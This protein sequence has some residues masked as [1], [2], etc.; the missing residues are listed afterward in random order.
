MI[1]RILLLVTSGILI[2]NCSMNNHSEIK[3][4]K[5]LVEYAENP[6]NIDEGHPRF[7]WIISIDE[8]NQIQSAYRILVASSTLKLAENSGD[9]WN[10]GKVISSVTIQHEPEGISL[11]SNQKYFWKVMV[12]DGAGKEFESPVS[13]F[14]T[15]ILNAG[16]WQ[17]SWIGEGTEPEVLPEKGFI[18]SRKD[19]TLMKD[20]I[21]HHGNSILLRNEIDLP[22]KIKSAKTPYHKYVLYDSYDIAQLLK[23]GKNTLG[24]HLGNGWYNPYK[25][26]WNQYRMQWFGFKKAI[27]QIEITNEDGSSQI[28]KTD[29]NWKWADGPEISNCVYDGEIYDA[30]LDQQGWNTIDFDGS[31]WKAV[32]LY[33]TEKVRLVSQ[34]MP[35][36]KVN[37]TVKPRE[38]KVSVV[39]TNQIINTLC[40]NL[41]EGLCGNEDCGQ[42]SA[43]YVKMVENLNMKWLME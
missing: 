14:E 21:P 19:E 30:N 42:M 11:K 3:F 33:R 20:S 28:V 35:A 32:T 34:R 39:Y 25:K 31:G 22:K 24:I 40:Q 6:I 12:W 17:A 16:E 15:A 2:M 27:A 13:V 37:E 23:D 4:R 41:P 9:I 5:M 8:R 18:G 1:H 29:E 10:S 38:I 26:W 36:I 7:S 43:W